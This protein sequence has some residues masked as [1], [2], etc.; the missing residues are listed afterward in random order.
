MWHN[1]GA[2]AI[3]GGLLIAEYVGV[4]SVMRRVTEQALSPFLSV[5]YTLVMGVEYPFR[6]LYTAV[7]SNQ[8]IRELESNYADAVSQLYQLEGVAAENREL[9]ALLEDT[10]RSA[11]QV[12][13]ARPVFSQARSAIDVGAAENIRIGQVVLVR[14]TAVGLVSEVSERFSL[15]TLLADVREQSLVV[16]TRSGHRGLI[17]G[18][19]KHILLTELPSDA[20][21]QI[22]EPVVTLG[23]PGVPRDI[24]VGTIVRDITRDESPTKTFVI[25]QNVSFAEA[26]VVELYL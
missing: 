10:D 25:E 21:V 2:L 17:K 8:K 4:G 3:T 6:M 19:N 22:G 18:D 9:R 11:N 1:L 20:D 5:G 23:Q 13:I 14:N 15:V 7:G 26:R 12:L 16:S 24:F